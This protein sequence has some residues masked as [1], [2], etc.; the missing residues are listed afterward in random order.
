VPIEPIKV[1]NLNAKRGDQLIHS[2][3]NNI[4]AYDESRLKF[5]ALEGNGYFTS[6]SLIIHGEN[7]YISTN[8]LTFYFYTRSDILLNK[9]AYIKRSDNNDVNNIDDDSNDS[10]SA[11][12]KDYAND[13]SNLLLNNTPENSLLFIDGPLIGGQM[14]SLTVNLNDSLLDKKITPIFFVKNSTSNLITDNIPVLKG[15]FNSDMHWAYNV[16][17]PGKRTSLFQYEDENNPNYSKIFCYLQA[18]NVSPQRIEFHKKTFEI[19]KDQIFDIMDMIYYL[20]LV[21]GNLNNPQIRS[22]AIA[23]K[24]ARDTLKLYDI[25]YL[26]KTSGVIPTMN[27]VRF[28]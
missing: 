8:L 13:R 22:I 7:D 20:I 26:I 1:Y 9:S 18:H 25:N 5:S 19:I 24:F 2:Y 27:Q 17:T 6:H 12:K 11:Y 28:G 15:N 21:Q 23:E 4:L 16:L 14:S 3:P 10:E